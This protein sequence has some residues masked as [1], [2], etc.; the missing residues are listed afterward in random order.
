[1]EYFHN[2]HIFAEKDAQGIWHK[3]LYLVAKEDILGVIS[4]VPIDWLTHSYAG[5]CTI[6]IV[7]VLVVQTTVREKKN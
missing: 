4:K 3:L 5:A 2:L 6:M 7:E 1:M